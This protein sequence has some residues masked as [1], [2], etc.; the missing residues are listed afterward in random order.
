MLE[1]KMF[2]EGK[3]TEVEAAALAGIKSPARPVKALRNCLS[4]RRPP[5]G[6]LSTVRRLL[7]STVV[8]GIIPALWRYRET[9]LA[10]AIQSRI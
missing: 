6:P 4:P 7:Y 5:K 1:N 2:D 8:R 9:S 10:D 3:K